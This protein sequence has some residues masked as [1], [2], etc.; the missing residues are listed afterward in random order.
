MCVAIDAQGSNYDIGYNLN[1]LDTNFENSRKLGVNIRISIATT[2]MWKGIHKTIFTGEQTEIDNK[3]DNYPDIHPSNATTGLPEELVLEV[4]ANLTP[5][6]ANSHILDTLPPDSDSRAVC[7]HIHLLLP[8]NQLQRLIIKRILDYAIKFKR[9][10]F[11]DSREQLLKYIR[12]EGRVGK[13]RVVKAIEMG[14]ILLSRRKELVISA[15][16]GSTAN[17]I[18]R[19]TVHSTLDINNQAKKNYQAKNNI[20]WLY[21]S[22]LIIDKVNMI[23]LKL[24]TS[25]DKQLQKARRLDSHL[26]TVFDRLLLLVLMRDFYQFAPVLG[27]EFWN[28]PIGEDEIHGKSFWNRFTII[29]TLTEQMC[30]K[31]DLPFQEMLRRARDE[32]LGFQNVEA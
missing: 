30:Q 27:K 19:S 24:L 21:C 14:F 2:D 4:M 17:S 16:T 22:S 9:K 3:P 8:L 28:H 26:T 23:D 18:G 6:P 15:S 25:I 7:D 13:G 1:L 11:F 5:K 31:T 12:G 29:L 20:Q 10:M 32:K